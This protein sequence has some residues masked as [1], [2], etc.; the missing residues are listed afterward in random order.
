MIYLLESLKLRDDYSP[1]S[2]DRQAKNLAANWKLIAEYAAEIRA[3]QEHDTE[4]QD[5]G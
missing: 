5:N 3:R 2:L 1:K 4:E